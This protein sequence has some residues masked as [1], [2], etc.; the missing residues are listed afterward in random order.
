MVR[1][2]S[3]RCAAQLLVRILS[4]IGA[5]APYESFVAQWVALRHARKRPA[6]GCRT[7][8]SIGSVT[9]TTYW[10][11]RTN[12]APAKKPGTTEEW[13]LLAE[14][15]VPLGRRWCEHVNQPQTEAELDAI[16]QCVSRGR[17]FGGDRWRSKVARQLGLEYTFR[18]RGRPR[19][20][21]PAESQLSDQK[22]DPRPLV[23]PQH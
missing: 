18:S 13:A 20:S 22:N 12:N 4:L 16:R 15:P 1:S 19:K 11:R 8:H 3:A 5:T 6:S 2:P 23:C 14:S 10:N 17:P 9:V 21:P 7:Q